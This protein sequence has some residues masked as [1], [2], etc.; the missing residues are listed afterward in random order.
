MFNPT[1]PVPIIITDSPI[2]ILESLY[3]KNN[4]KELLK[5]YPEYSSKSVEVNNDFSNYAIKLHELY[6]KCKINNEYIDLEKN[7]KKSICDV[8]NLFKDERK[9]NNQS[10]KITYNHICNI[11][12]NYDTA[13]LYSIIYPK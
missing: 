2:L 3:K 10:F 11:L 8:H 12:R 9:N 13:Y 7:F 1:P 4:I 6:I 5:Y